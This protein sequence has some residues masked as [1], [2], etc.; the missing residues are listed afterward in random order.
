[1]ARAIWTGSINFGLVT[2]P[3]SLRPAEES[4][5]ELKFS[6]VDRRDLSPVGY[7]RISK[8]TG[9]EVPW[10]QVVRGYEY[11][12][13]QYVVLT[14][15][16][17]KGAN[18]KASQS[19]D[20]FAFV[21]AAEIEPVYFEKPYYLEPAKKNSKAYALLRETLRRSAKVGL[22]KVVIRTRQRLAALFVRDAVLTLEILRYPHELREP[23]SIEAPAGD[24]KKLG[25]TPKESAMAEQIVES[26]ASSWRPED[27]RDDYH[28][29]ILALVRRKVKSGKTEE[30]EEPHEKKPRMAEV[31]DLMPLLK[32]S[33]EK[34][35]AKSRRPRG[36]GRTPAKARRSRSA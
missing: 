36:A 15:R 27:Y 25:V 24:L 8:A 30:I 33:I 26:M 28:D 3:V 9:K 20:I 32:K 35:Q 18:P 23:G 1:M 22:A 11:K 21:D 17:I 34:T 4:K 14:D 5:E 12:E 7:E 31:V 13:G 2:I 10:D 19:I 29:D 16:E 6:Y